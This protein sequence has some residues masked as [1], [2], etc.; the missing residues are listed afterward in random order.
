VVL[1]DQ[2]EPE[3]TF[4]KCPDLHVLKIEVVLHIKQQYPQTL[5]VRTLH[6]DQVYLLIILAIFLHVQCVVAQGV[7]ELVAM[8]EIQEMLEIQ[9]T[10]GNRLVD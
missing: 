4:H 3:G 7:V 9:A 8:L 10:L 2:E 1:E 6:L 5:R